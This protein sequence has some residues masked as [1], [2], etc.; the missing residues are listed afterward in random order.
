MPFRGYRILERE[1]DLLRVVPF[2]GSPLW[3]RGAR[4]SSTCERLAK[5]QGVTYTLLHPPNE[6]LRDLQIPASV[7][8]SHGEK[9]KDHLRL[10]APFDDGSA[11][12]RLREWIAAQ[13]PQVLKVMENADELASFLV[14]QGPTAEV[15]RALAIWLC[16]F[17]AD[18]PRHSLVDR[19]LT[20]T[21]PLKE[22][23]GIG[24]DGDLSWILRAAGFFPKTIPI[25]WVESLRLHWRTVLMGPG[26]FQLASQVVQN[27]IGALRGFIKEEATRIYDSRNP[28]EKQ[29]LEGE[30]RIIFGDLWIQARS[31]Q[32]TGW[33]RLPPDSTKEDV[34]DWYHSYR[35]KLSWPMPIEGERLAAAQSF[36][37][38][39]LNPER[40]AKW[41]IQGERGPLS[42]RANSLIRDEV[43]A[44]DV[45][46]LVIADGLG[47]WEQGQL[48]RKIVEKTEAVKVAVDLPIFATL[49]TVT[50]VCKGSLLSGRPQRDWKTADLK[51]MTGECARKGTRYYYHEGFPV[52]KVITWMCDSETSLVVLNY[53]EIDKALHSAPSGRESE[54]RLDGQLTTLA[55]L[56]SDVADAV[57]ADVAKFSIMIVSDH[58]QVVGPC[59]PLAP[60]G[61]I[62]KQRLRRGDSDPESFE[63]LLRKQESLCTEDYL[64]ISDGHA[65][66]EGT[67]PVFGCHGG[68]FPEEVITRVSVLQPKP[69][70][71]HVEISGLGKGVAGVN[72]AVEWRAKNCSGVSLTV[73]RVR[74]VFGD[75]SLP[76]VPPGAPVPAFME[77]PFDAQRVNGW[78]TPEEAKSAKLQVE[79]M[80]PAAKTPFVVEANVEIVSDSGYQVTEFSL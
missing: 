21:D 29:G 7:L 78:P 71:P 31:S 10:E 24:S 37:H 16:R 41:A 6:L 27:E 25:E 53:I 36:Q 8:K 74:L 50:A 57:V 73:A 32:Q 56:I 40:F 67:E 69:A 46:L 30:C 44:N 51:D 9:L 22:W 5:D 11:V 38:W 17:Q 72:G 59:V 70:L 79:L 13:F 4:I 68:A 39:Y 18:S 42:F 54:A 2:D 58:G 1:S 14:A 19:I 65:W 43:K 76:L 28:K 80:M 62:F 35:R 49:P 64:F 3:V 26:G 77:R 12:N 48:V 15:E 34:C 52:E 45:L 63:V 23:M 33:T 61:V 47:H 55:R 66:Q 60:K 75:K 20:T